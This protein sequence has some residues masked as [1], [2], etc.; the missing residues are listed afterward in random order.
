MKLYT[1][2]YARNGKHMD[3][4]AISIRAPWW[5]G[6]RRTYP[7]LAPTWDMVLGVKN[8]TMTQDEYT[9][10]FKKILAKLD[11]Q[12]VANELGDGAIM[13][14]Y[15]SPNDFCHRHIVAEWM[16]NAG[17]DVRELLPEDPKR[18]QVEDLFSFE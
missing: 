9:V 15:E 7:A 14:C 12:D 5:Y 17:I 3:A 16:R 2:N 13:L 6:N 10:E 1:S 4:V 8:G 11:P 18:K